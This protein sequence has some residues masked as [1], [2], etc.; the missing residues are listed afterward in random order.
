MI[1]AIENL[2]KDGLPR[3]ECFH[4]RINTIEYLNLNIKL[5]IKKWQLPKAVA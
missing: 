4:N 3:L 2:K 1:R 5:G